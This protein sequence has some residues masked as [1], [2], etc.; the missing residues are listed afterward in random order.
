MPIPRAGEAAIGHS[1]SDRGDAGA[2]AA[3]RRRIAKSCATVPSMA[4]SIKRGG[5][6]NWTSEEVRCGARRRS[7]RG[8]PW[9]G[10][11][12]ERADL[13]GVSFH[14]VPGCWIMWRDMGCGPVFAR[15]GFCSGIGLARDFSTDVHS[16]GC[17]I[18][19][20]AGFKSGRETWSA[21][22][23]FAASSA[24][25]LGGDLIRYPA[26]PRP[27]PPRGLFRTPSRTARPPAWARCWCG[28]GAWLGCEPV[29]CLTGPAPSQPPP[30]RGGA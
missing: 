23:A 5:V 17:L 10:R 21:D 1:R 2:A 28:A 13:I 25:S 12:L 24:D 19:P 14:I 8:Q 16:H 20:S 9:R 30:A 15:A 29:W 7:R 26:R 6:S 18:S 4:P 22:G 3:K 27:R 11:A